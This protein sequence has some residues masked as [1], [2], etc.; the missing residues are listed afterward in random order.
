M[1]KRL[2]VAFLLAATFQ[3]ASRA[4]QSQPFD[5]SPER[6][7]SETPAVTVPAQESQP[8]DGTP[9]NP[10]AGQGAAA[11]ADSSE[12]TVSQPAVTVPASDAST[13]F[14]RFLLPEGDISLSGEIEDRS[15]SVYLT[16][17]QAAAGARLNIGYQNSI[18]VAPESSRLMI[19]VNDT[20]IADD[21]ISSPDGVSER[22]FDVPAG[23]LNPGS[24]IVHIRSEQRHRTDCTIQSTY[25]LWSNVNAEKTFLTFGANNAGLLE[26]LDDIRAIGTDEA[27]LTRLNFVVPALEQPSATIPLMRLAQGLSVLA[28][29]PN[30]SFSFSATTLTPAGA[31]AMTVLVGTAAELRPLLPTL[32][33][34][35]ATAPIAG[36]IPDPASQRSILVISAPTWQ[37]ITTAIESIVAPTDIAS[38]ASRRDAL[39]TSRWRSPDA[40]LLFSDTRLSFAQLGIATEQFTGRRFRRDFTV[41][42]PADFYANA[43]GEAVIRLDAAYSPAVLPGSHIDIY[44]NGSIASTVPITSSGGGILRKLPI[45]VTMRH[46]KP[47]VN[48]IAVEALL[49]TDEDKACAPGTTGLQT[50]RFA[51][52]DTSEFHM[53]DFARIAQVPSLEAA[54]G[55]GYPYG[56]SATTV[57]LFMDRI[58]ADTMSAAASLLGR[59]AVAAGHP[60]PFETVASPSLIGNRS[61][62][63]IG[64]LSQMPQNVL[65]QMNIS[66]SSRSSWG[67]EAAGDGAGMDNQAALDEWQSM[68]R[69]GLW[70]GKLAAAE[71]WIKDTFDIS[72]SSLR[73]TPAGDSTFMPSN[74]STLLF[75]QGPTPDGTGTWSLVAAPSGKD[76][77]EGMQSLTDKKRWEQL[78]GHLATYDGG[79]KSVHSLEANAITLLPTQ[80]ASFSNYRLI[81]ANWLSSNILTYAVLLAGVGL[82]LGIATATMLGNLGR[83]E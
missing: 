72:M 49:E 22:G 62:V 9:Q 31:G 61:A 20:R 29:M 15:W 13:A 68:L 2:L 51:L 47:G 75:A 71:K 55:T 7:V 26:S 11:E 3:T 69:G 73:F 17:A 23:V 37:G 45:N 32:P 70:N 53:P 19:D 33:P 78:S 76:L 38:M 63:F 50:P 74:E 27:G 41:A 35:A 8:A 56:R 64:S 28:N 46:F 25:E 42:V 30:Q 40:P 14:K 24:N 79:D 67:T 21:A 39:A 12:P 65:A 77:S 81:A 36:F 66:D 16:P 10:P 60:I 80:P 4:Q 83:R 44:V 57:P 54:A 1:I 43:Y 34:N 48:T 58:D 82:L 6:P 5:M 18:V 59:L 52:F